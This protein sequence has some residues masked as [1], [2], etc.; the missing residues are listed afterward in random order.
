MPRALLLPLLLLCSLPS[1][2]A[3]SSSAARDVSAAASGGAAS[4]SAG[5]FA[6]LL[7][8]AQ[9]LS[10]GSAPPKGGSASERESC[11][12]CRYL[13]RSAYDAAGRGG[14]SSEEITT[15]LTSICLSAPPA[16]RQ[17]CTTMVDL[18][19]EIATT[20]GFGRDFDDVCE[21]MQLCWDG[22]MLSPTA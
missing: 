21:D 1:S 9:A 13:L 18:K 19:E 14:A 11:F 7:M 8:A 6:P 16:Y 4:R 20:L 15:A 22:L 5:S 10:P 17:G 2:S 3:S 12:A